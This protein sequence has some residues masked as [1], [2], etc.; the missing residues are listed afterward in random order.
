MDSLDTKIKQF[1]FYSDGDSRNIPADL[2]R[3]QL[4]SGRIF[5]QANKT[6]KQ[7]NIRSNI[8]GKFFI[9]ENADRIEL[10]PKNLLGETV[11][12]Y[13]MNYLNT[14]GIGDI[15]ADLEIVTKIHNHNKN[16]TKDSTEPEWYL[17]MDILYM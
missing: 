16:L 4:R 10:Y 12:C 13:D 5:R 1:Q 11:Y 2:T 14:T 7:L 15:S 6:I 8:P 9:N 17:F 3:V